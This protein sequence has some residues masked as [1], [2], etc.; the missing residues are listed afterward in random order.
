MDS[1]CAAFPILPGKSEAARAFLRELAGPRSEENAASDRRVGITKE[2]WFFQNL[3]TGDL[4]IG[5]AEGE[6]LARSLGQIAASQ[7]PSDRWFKDRM[8]DLT[9]VDLNQMEGAP[10]ERLYQYE[11]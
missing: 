10:S 7:E 1:V 8:L 6:D 2:A 11:A 4:L 5:Y 3:P 9:G